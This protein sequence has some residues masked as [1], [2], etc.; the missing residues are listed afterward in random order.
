VITDGPTAEALASPEVRR[1]VIGGE[2]H[3]PARAGQA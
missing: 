1:Y 2:I 3:R